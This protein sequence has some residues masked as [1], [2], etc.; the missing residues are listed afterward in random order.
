MKGY[1]LLKRQLVRH[2]RNCRFSFL[3]LDQL[4]RGKRK[5]EMKAKPEDS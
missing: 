4:S 3:T 2:L 5:I 1:L